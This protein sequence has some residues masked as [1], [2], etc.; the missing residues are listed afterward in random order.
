V[1]GPGLLA[2]V[3]AFNS[4]QIVYRKRRVT[5]NL[6]SKESAGPA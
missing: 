2:L 1:L 6:P 3:A 4:R 5:D